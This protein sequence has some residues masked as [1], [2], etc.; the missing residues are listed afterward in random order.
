M[1]GRDTGDFQIYDR[2]RGPLATPVKFEFAFRKLVVS[3][4]QAKS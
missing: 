3:V 1:N 4:E 2:E